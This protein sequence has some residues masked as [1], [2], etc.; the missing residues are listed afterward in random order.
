MANVIY[1]RV[2]NGFETKKVTTPVEYTDSGKTKLG[3]RTQ[4][5]TAPKLEDV[6]VF[7]LQDDLKM[8]VGSDM[9]TFSDMFP[10][11][12]SFV[13]TITSYSAALTGSQSEGMLDLAN[14]FDVPRWQKTKPISFNLTLPFYTIT[15][16]IKD[17]YNPMK[18]IMSLTVL[19]KLQNG[20]YSVPGLSAISIQQAKKK[21]Q[22]EG[23]HEFGKSA[24]LI[25]VKIPGIIYMPYAIIT[26]ASPTYSKQLTKSGYPLWGTLEIDVQGL[27]PALDTDFNGGK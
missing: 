9:S 16:P 23:A 12:E 13:N 22:K 21:N 20:V 4:V 27:Y 8:E 3:S 6:L 5:V 26:K 18:L 17:V 15:N 7:P 24:K 2:I 19:T 25:S 11:L 10:G 1:I 14:M